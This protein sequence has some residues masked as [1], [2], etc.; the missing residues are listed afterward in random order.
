[1][2]RF[3]AAA[4]CLVLAGAHVGAEAAVEGKGAALNMSDEEL[5]RM[6]RSA[7]PPHISR[8]ATIVA[9]GADGKLRTLRKGT[10]EFTCFADLSGQ[11]APDPVCADRAGTEWLTSMLEG[12]ERPTN[13]TPGVGYMGQ[14]GWHWEKDGKVVMDPST[15]GA[16]RVKEPPHWMVLWPMDPKQAALPDK[17]TRFGA[18]V[19]YPDTPYSHLMID[20]D[21][22]KLPSGAPK[23]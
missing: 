12:R 1:M 3:L 13:T 22:N 19:M 17:P 14:G 23:G 5:S 7:A 6:A 4:A 16:K 10:N 8:N 2:R 21:P 18:F 15:P 9:A 11:E 20:Q